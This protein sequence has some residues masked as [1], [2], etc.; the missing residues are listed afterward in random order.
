MSAV[1]LKHKEIKGYR[2][3]LLKKQKGICPVCKHKIPEKEAVLDH[4]HSKGH[5]RCVLHRRCN[6][7]E[8]KLFN[9]FRSYGFPNEVD[10]HTALTAIVDYWASD[11][12]DNPLHPTHRTPKDKAIRNLRKRYRSAK[13]ETTKRR[14][15]AE[16]DALLRSEDE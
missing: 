12:S 7:L 1:K 9:W 15:Q 3:E 14:I 2:A 10:P 6:V 5:V 8:G 11:Y 13:R 4:D 16:I